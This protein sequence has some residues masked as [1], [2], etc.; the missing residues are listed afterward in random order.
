MFY[1]SSSWFYDIN[2]LL[3]SKLFAHGCFSTLNNHGYNS[4]L[5]RYLYLL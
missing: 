2:F 5:W 4:I 1:G 3:K